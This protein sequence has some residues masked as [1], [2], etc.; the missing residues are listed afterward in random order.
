MRKSN[1][2]VSWWPTLSGLGLLMVFLL[3]SIMPPG[4]VAALI[5]RLE[6]VYYDWRLNLTA[7]PITPANIPIIIV[8]IDERSLV[9]Q[10]RWPWSRTTLAQ[11]TETLKSDGA[12]VVGYDML[13]AEPELDPVSLALNQMPAQLQQEVEQRWSQQ[14]RPLHGDSLFAQALAG[15][16]GVLGFIMHLTQPLQV[17]QL[18]ESLNIQWQG[19]ATGELSVLRLAGYTAPLGVL[20]DQALG[21]G[22]ITTFPDT[23]GVIRRTPLLLQ[24]QDQF[25]AALSLEMARLYYLEDRITLATEPLGDRR[26]LTSLSLAKRLH[27]LDHYGQVLIPYSATARP[28]LRVSAT[29]VVNARIAPHTFEN[30][31]VLIGTSAIGLGDLVTTPVATRMAGVEVHATVL[32][33]LLNTDFPYR[34]D[35]A[36]GAEWL[37]MLLVGL[38]LALSLPRLSPVWMLGVVVLTLL[39]L[40]GS[41]LS[42]WSFAG[43]DLSLILTL[44][45][46]LVMFLLNVTYQLFIENHARRRIKEMFGQYV[47]AAHIDEMLLNPDAYHFDGE[48][49]EMTVLFSDIR[50]FTSISEG[51]TAEALKKML[52]RYFTPITRTIFEHE[53]TIDKY[54][55]DMVMAFWN[56]PLRDP[57]HAEH[58]IDAALSMLSLTEQLKQAFK[59]EGLPEIN[60]GIGINTGLMNVGDM[61]SSYR[62]AYTVLGDAV[63]LGSRL[64]SITKFYGVKLL[65]GERTKA[66]APA[67]CYR[68]VDQIQVKGKDEAV[69]VYE[70]V[71]RA[72]LL[73]DTLVQAVE[74]HH[75]ALQAYYQQDWQC[76]RDLWRQ[77]QQ[78]APD[79]VLYGLYLER[80]QQLQHVPPSQDWDGTFRHTTK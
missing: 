1:Q 26:S 69:R 46:I 57:H 77:L 70:P 12:L 14:E 60:I 78:A 71:G 40:I 63:N 80:I 22:F 50:S 20:Q 43:L 32:H 9:E 34:P 66:L 64:E 11:M 56:A 58:A 44:L 13:F 72:E 29:D 23:D 5:E 24:F 10:G 37:T 59:S 38:L 48:T 7:Q 67:F 51:L 61:G 73:S 19:E 47:P 4:P 49:Q 42:F 25:Y 8:D 28:F 6:Y 75:L 35:W 17:G 33:A 41:N 53:G 45:L 76:A 18:P 16:D 79:C 27:R 31:L 55:G 74:Q 21:A 30:A 68:L 52:N 15:V 3:H 65:V 2:K 62:R 36:E 39:L 54:V